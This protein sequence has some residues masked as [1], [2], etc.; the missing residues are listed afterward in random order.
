MH[1]RTSEHFKGACIPFKLILVMEWKMFTRKNRFDVSIIQ[2]MKSHD[3]GVVVMFLW[4]NWSSSGSCF[5]QAVC[6]VLGSYALVKEHDILVL[7]TLV[8]QLVAFWFESNVPE[9][10][11]MHRCKQVSVCMYHY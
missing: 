11:Q 3:V 4:Q 1:G 7:M 10:P 6:D 9:N 2:T 5:I 8:N